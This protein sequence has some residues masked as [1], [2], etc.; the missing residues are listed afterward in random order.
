[1]PKN[2]YV[3]VEDFLL[4][5]LLFMALGGMTWAVRGCSGYGAMNGC[6]FA[7]VT[8]GAAWWFLARDREGEQSRRYNSGWIVFALAFGTGIAGTRGWMQWPSFFEGK[9]LLDAPHDKWVPIDRSYGF[10]WQFISGIP[11]AGLGACML[12]WCGSARRVG[13]IGW[14]VRIGCGFAGGALGYLVFISLPDLVLPL[15]AT[16]KAEYA[17]FVTNPNLRRLAGDNRLALQHLGVYLG[18]LIFELGRRE[19]KNVLLILTVG[20]IN[21]AGWAALQNWRWAAPIWPDVAMNWW[22]CWESS[23]GLSIGLAYGVAWFLV[24]RRMGDGER[25]RCWHLTHATMP[26][27][28]RWGLYFGLIYGLGWSIKCGLKGFANIYWT[29]QPEEYWDAKIALV[30]YPGMLALAVL[31]ALW[32]RA[33]PRTRD[34]LRDLFPHAG[35]IISLVIVVQNVLAQM[36]TGP[37]SSW[38]EMA[39]VVYYV[40]LMLISAVILWHTQRV[41]RW[42]AV[43]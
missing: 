13:W 3:L 2:S 5:T 21:G 12:A 1:M 14:G 8:W 20:L 24:N 36:V 7:G 39:F 11:W 9:L 33:T 40:F 22:R 43:G 32:V 35:K 15:H 23:G 16:L 38:T 4:P 31:A 17:D 30:A 10:V 42:E 27:L 25:E 41:R 26:N 29:E 6:I 34:D 19:W 18:F 28:E 37:H